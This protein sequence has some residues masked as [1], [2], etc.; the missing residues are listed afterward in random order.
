MTSKEE[1]IEILKQFDSKEDTVSQTLFNVYPQEMAAICLLIDR[2]NRR[3]DKLAKSFEDAFV[4]F[5]KFC[6]AVNP[7][8]KSLSKPGKR[9][10]SVTKS[11]N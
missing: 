6:E 5:G 3:L 8:K 1:L 9:Y 2:K 4:A 10:S 11:V 7:I